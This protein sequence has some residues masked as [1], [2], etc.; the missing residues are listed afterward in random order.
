MPRTGSRSRAPSLPSVIRAGQVTGLICRW[1]FAVRLGTAEACHLK[2]GRIGLLLPDSGSSAF[3]WSLRTQPSVGAG[4]FGRCSEVAP[5]CGR[6]PG[7]CWRSGTVTTGV[8]P[9]Q[10]DALDLM[11]MSAT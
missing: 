8:R 10:P 1:Q 11:S 6:R 5:G 7:W 9:G 4:G 3:R 2:S